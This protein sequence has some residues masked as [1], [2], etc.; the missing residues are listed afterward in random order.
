MEP[1]KE[2]KKDAVVTKEEE[3]REDLKE[4]KK[5]NSVFAG[6]IEE[7][8]KRFPKLARFCIRSFMKTFTKIQE[9]NAKRQKAKAKAKS[10]GGSSDA[11]SIAEKQN[12]AALDRVVDKLSA[13]IKRV[14]T[15]ENLKKR[16]KALG[17]M[18]GSFGRKAV[19]TANTLGKRGKGALD[20]KM[21]NKSPSAGAKKNAQKKEPGQRSKVEKESGSSD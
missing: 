12:N 18:V 14:S 3:Y 10:A 17:A 8:N 16:G 9:L 4:I 6:K 2:H 1:S 5:V 19:K 11:E 15:D 7:C 20:K 13:T 21:A